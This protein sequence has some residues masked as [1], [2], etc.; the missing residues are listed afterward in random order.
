MFYISDEFIRSLVEED[1]HIVDMTVLA[2]GIEEER[3]VVSCFPKRPCV[4]A[5]VEEAARVFECVGAK[6]EILAR[7]GSRLEAGEF[8]LRAEGTAGQLHASYK[9]AQN[10][11][12]YM[13]GIATRC[14]D[15]VAAA[16][17][18]SPHIEVCVTRK[19]FPGSKRLSIKAALAGGASIH[20]LG[21]SDSILVFDQHR[22]FV[23]GVEGCAKKISSMVT[24]FPEKKIA[25]E[26]ATVEEALLFAR[27]GAD[28]L[29]CERFSPDELRETV[30]CVA[31][32]NPAARVSAA[33]GVNA[34][35]AAEFAA[36]GVHILVTSWVYFGKPQDIKMRFGSKG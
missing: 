22:V 6:A 23:G 30:R 29:Q 17:S 9:T 13:S 1:L 2:M 8:C 15:M 27:S 18:V 35:N 12:E 33:G 7:S 5:G 32:I 36:T 20:R 34:D 24:A 11:M 21:L 10:V 14:A 26:V 25:V 3:G 16:R 19:H 31:E 4:I 28:V